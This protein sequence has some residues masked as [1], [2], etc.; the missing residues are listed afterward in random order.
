MASRRIFKR[1]I[2]PFVEAELAEAAELERA[3]DPE[4]AFRHLEAA[5]VLGQPSTTLH[6][7]AH[8]EMLRWGLRQHDLREVLGQLLRIVGAATKTAIGL[9]PE[10][11]TGGSRVSAFRPLPLRDEHAQLLAWA[12]SD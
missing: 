6:V 12:R 7:R 10:G 2:T 1:R 5:H 4:G 11:N 9:L 8:L 3:G